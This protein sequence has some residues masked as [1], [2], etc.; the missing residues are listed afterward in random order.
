MLYYRSLLTACLNLWNSCQKR[1]VSIMKKIRY[2]LWKV[3]GG[4]GSTPSRPYFPWDPDSPDS[5]SPSL[6]VDFTVAIYFLSMN[7]LEVA[8]KVLLSRESFPRWCFP[9]YSRNK[10]VFGLANHNA[11]N[12]RNFVSQLMKV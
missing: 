4:Q 10:S 5:E 1:L 12:D 7:A 11:I 3:L 9:P 6:H 2:S 8:V